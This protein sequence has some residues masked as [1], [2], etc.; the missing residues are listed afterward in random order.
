MKFMRTDDDS[1]K[2]II[3]VIVMIAACILLYIF[4]SKRSTINAAT[5][6][7]QVAVEQKRDV[8]YEELIHCYNMVLKR[9]MID[10][11][12]YFIDVLSESEEYCRLDCLLFSEDKDEIFDLSPADS[13][14][15]HNNW[16]YEISGE[17][18]KY[19]SKY[20]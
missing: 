6:P 20:E 8:T 14:E 11:P 5:Q 2:T 13:I 15:Y 18:S 17:P 10:N 1:K 4:G 19:K 16:T 7:L 3:A 12:S 9:V